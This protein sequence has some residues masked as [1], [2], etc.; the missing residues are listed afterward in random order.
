MHFLLLSLLSLSTCVAAETKKLPSSDSSLQK[1][2]EGNLRYVS[3]TPQNTEPLDERRRELASG[4][5]PFAIIIGC[6]DSRVPPEIIFDQS[7]GDLFV[8]RVAGNVA[9]PIEM[10][11]IE[12]S[13]DKLRTPLIF[14][15]GHQ[16]CGAVKAVLQGTAN[17]D[18]EN[19]APLIQEAVDA[20][21]NLPGDPFMNAVK[22]NV[23]LNKK[24]LEE[25]PILQA[26][27]KQKK[28]KIV[29]GYYELE[30]G[31]VRLL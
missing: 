10:D 20:A 12:Y 31:Q 11:S 18:L 8:V 29:G 1:L 22:A 4:Q 14:V 25:N 19:I 5:N 30:S 13:A 16:G 21:K 9:G 26:L 6:S 23:R 7:L 17:A 28:L 27:I 15:L 24:R 2:M 3:D